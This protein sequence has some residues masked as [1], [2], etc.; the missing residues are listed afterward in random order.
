MNLDETTLDLLAALA[1]AVKSR[2]PALIERA[3]DNLFAH[4]CELLGNR[5]RE[6]DMDPIADLAFRLGSWMEP[7]SL[8]FKGEQ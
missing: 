2:H 3:A 5:L 6:T 8:A 7:L 1:Q 4:R